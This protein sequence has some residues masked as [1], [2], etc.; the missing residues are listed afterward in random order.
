MNCVQQQRTNIASWVAI[1]L[2]PLLVFSCVTPPTDDVKE[3]KKEVVHNS[4][5][6][7][8][9][10]LAFNKAMIEKDSAALNKLMYKELVYGHSN[11]W[12]QIRKEVIDDLYNGTITYTKI[13]HPEMEVIMAGD[14]ASL[15][16]DGVYEADY[17]GAQ[18][19]FNLRVMQTWKYVD[20]R[21]QMLNRQSVGLAVDETKE[22]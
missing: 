19:V 3:E 1:V 13:E 6:V 14:V 18:K 7:R 5:E 12:L 20:G 21:W 16:T 22:D 17:E 2:L 9:A 4:E 15:R 10:A 8:E 11:G